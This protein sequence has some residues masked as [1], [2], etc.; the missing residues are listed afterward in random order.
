M[1]RGEERKWK[2]LEAFRWKTSFPITAEIHQRKGHRAGEA[3][4]SARHPK[5]GL[6]QDHQC[7]RTKGWARSFQVLPEPRQKWREWR[8]ALRTLHDPSRNSSDLTSQ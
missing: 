6:W 3:P 1:E 4:A 2:L 8:K 7:D 5:Q